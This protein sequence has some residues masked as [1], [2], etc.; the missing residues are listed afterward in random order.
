MQT[1]T[2]EDDDISTEEVSGIRAKNH[3]DSNLAVDIIDSDP[4]PEDVYFSH[5]GVDLLIRGHGRGYKMDAWWEDE[6]GDTRQSCN[7]IHFDEDG[8]IS[9]AVDNDAERD[10]TLSIET[11]E[12]GEP[13]IVIEDPM[14]R[15]EPVITDPGATLRVKRNEYGYR[16]TLTFTNWDGEEVTNWVNMPLIDSRDDNEAFMNIAYAH[17]KEAAAEEDESDDAESAA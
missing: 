3:N 17:I 13:V 4:E 15:A 10:P 1:Q 5:A 14:P 11:D 7:H 2:D 6:D 8:P 9:P 12:D 16:V